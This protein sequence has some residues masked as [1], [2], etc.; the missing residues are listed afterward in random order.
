MTT[1]DLLKPRLRVVVIED[2][3]DAA[4]N[5]KQLL[6]MSGYEVKVA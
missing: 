6:E 2:D 1:S 5:L 3:R 4:D